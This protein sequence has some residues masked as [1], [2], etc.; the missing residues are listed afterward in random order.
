[1][2]SEAWRGGWGRSWEVKPVEEYA[3]KK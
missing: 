3:L 2:K 1:M